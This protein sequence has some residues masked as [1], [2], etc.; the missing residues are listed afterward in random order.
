MQFR[1]FSSYLIEE[2]KEVVFT[3]GR[4][5]PPTIG[6]EKLIN[7]VASLAKGNNYRIYASHSHDAKKNPLDHPT[8]TKFMRK[9]FPKHGRNIIMDHDV[10]NALNAL[11]KLYDQGFTKVIMVVGSDRVMEF[12]ALTTKYNGVKARHG[13]YNFEDGINVVSAGERDPDADDVSG[14]SASKM[15]AAAADNDFATFSKGLPSSFKDGQELFDTLRKAMGI[16]EA[17]EYHK[18]I[19]LEPISEER[20]AFV[21]G[22]LFAIGDEV[23]IKESGEIATISALGANYVIVETTSGK[24]RKWLDAVERIDEKMKLPQDPDIKDREGSQPKK[25]FSGMAK[26]TK[27]K[28]DAEFQKRAK[29]KDDDPRAYKQD[30]PGDASAETKPSRY[31]KKFKDMFGEESISEGNTETALRKKA[32]Q[33]GISYGILKKVFDRGVAAWKIGHRPGT[34]PAQWGMARVNSFATGG[35][36]QKTTD[37]DLWKQHKGQ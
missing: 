11:T 34:T 7:K 13:F 31:T 35:K 24:Y 33:T 4:F 5:N 1:S 37:A 16:K 29:M 8:K 36:T 19:Q 9:M 22:E 2:T 30:I 6:H 15:R 26:S 21:K 20:E 12:S 10:K 27:A 23:I 25:F 18:H 28:R 14:M 3:F 17:S 32:E